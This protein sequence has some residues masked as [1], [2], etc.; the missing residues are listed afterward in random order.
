LH[1]PEADEKSL[2]RVL[3]NGLDEKYKAGEVSDKIYAAVL[4]W[5]ASK[6]IGF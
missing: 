4:R 1:A 5:G 2:I 3:R 6:E